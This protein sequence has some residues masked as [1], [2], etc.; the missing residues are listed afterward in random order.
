VTPGLSGLLWFVWAIGLVVT[1][2]V[3]GHFLDRWLWFGEKPDLWLMIAGHVVV[4]M[5]FAVPVVYVFT[6]PLTAL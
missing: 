3:A 4:V 5:F 1:W 6:T 2:T